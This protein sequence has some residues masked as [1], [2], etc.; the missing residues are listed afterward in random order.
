MTIKEIAAYAKVSIA[1]VSRVINESGYVSPDKEQRVKD[2]LKELNYTPNFAAKKLRSGKSNT[3]GLISPDNSNPFFAQLGRYIEDLCYEKDYNIILCDS[4]YSIEKENEYINILTQH[5]VDGI[6]LVSSGNSENKSL[7]DS[8]IPFV[9]IDQDIKDNNG[10]CIS[11]NYEQ[12]AYLA[13]SH[14]ASFGHSRIA[15]ITGSLSSTI[16]KQRLTGYSQA[17]YEAGIEIDESLI[18]KSD[19]RMEGGY[20]AMKDLLA[21]K[22]P[23]TAVF[24]INDNMAIG[25][26]HAIHEA[27]LR[28]PEDISVAGYDDIVFSA[29]MNPPLTT[30]SHP[31]SNLA[32]TILELLFVNMDRMNISKYAEMYV[33]SLSIKPE[34]IVRKSTGSLNK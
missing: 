12:G 5:Q 33:N 20:N 24:A 3:I 6:I 13:V 15:C 23:P 17:L 7:V 26:M 30:V 31:V 25:A 16:P 18:V 8:G 22:N 19:F 1:T 9:T 28:I 11:I 14:L 4:D 34:L 29:V 10:H 21:R 32:K 27:G 2:A